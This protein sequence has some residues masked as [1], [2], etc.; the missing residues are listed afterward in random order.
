[1]LL[2]NNSTC[3]AKS[4]QANKSFTSPDIPERIHLNNQIFKEHFRLNKLSF[5]QDKAFLIH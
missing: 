5:Q 3:K 4:V 2:H 1:M